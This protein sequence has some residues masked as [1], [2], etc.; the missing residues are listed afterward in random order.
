MTNTIKGE[1]DLVAGDQTYRLFFGTNAMIGLEEKL[2]LNLQEIGQLLGSGKARIRQMRL[3][4]WSMLL[5]NH[6]VA[7]QDV[8]S[9]MDEAGHETAGEAIA[10]A[11]LAAMPKP[12]EGEVGEEPE[13]PQPA[14]KAA[15]KTGKRSG[16]A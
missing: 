12:K 1:V 5:E 14:A 3:M 8:G 15:A 4:L 9:I 13:R 16:K 7:E 11:F 2:D 6:D 10:L